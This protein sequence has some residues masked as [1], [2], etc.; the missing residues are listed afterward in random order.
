MTRVVLNVPG[1]SCGHCA[2]TVTEALTPIDGVRGVTVDVPTRRVQVEYDEAVANLEQM[3]AALA[4]EDYPVASAV[5][6]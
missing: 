6:A 2:K 4:E 1:I 5:P 3:K